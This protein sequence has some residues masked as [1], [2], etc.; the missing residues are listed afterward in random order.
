[1]NTKE[2]NNELLSLEDMLLSV[3][4]KLQELDSPQVKTED[5]KGEKHISREMLN[6]I[7]RQLTGQL[8]IEEME[9]EATTPEEMKKK[10]Q[11]KFNA[12]LKE[13]E[14]DDTEEESDKL[15]EV[16]MGNPEQIQ[17]TRT[18]LFDTTKLQDSPY[19]G[20]SE[21]KLLEY[22]EFK[23]NRM[24][25]ACDFVLR[26]YSTHTLH[27]SAIPPLYD[28]Q[29]QEALSDEIEK[30]NQAEAEPILE[31]SIDNIERLTKENDNTVGEHLVKL[32]KS[33][34]L[35]LWVVGVLGLITGIF[36]IISAASI[37]AD[38]IGFL[39]LGINFIAILVAGFFSK[40]T[41]IS[42]LKS[43]IHLKANRDSLPSLAMV[44][45]LIQLLFMLFAILTYSPDTNLFILTPVA[46]L[47]MAFHH[48]AKYFLASRCVR[49]LQT[50]SSREEMYGSDIVESEE[51]AADITKGT[52]YKKPFV[53]YNR[54]TSFI[55]HFVYNSFLDDMSDRLS[56]FLA[57]ASVLTSLVL[58]FIIIF[59][60]GSIFESATTLSACLCLFAPFGLMLSIQAPLYSLSKE[61]E[62]SSSAILGFSAAEEFAQLNATLTTAH[63]LFP[64][65]SVVLRGMRAFGHHPIDHSILTAASMLYATNSIL[66]D[67]FMQVLLNRTDILSPVDSVLLEDGLGISG[68]V[69]NRHVII[70]NRE[71]AINHNIEVP[72]EDEEKRL[73]PE[74]HKIVYLCIS[75]EL[76]A[77]FVFAL[78]A[79]E[80]TANSL[81]SLSER[82]ISLVVQTVD[83]AISSKTLAEVFGLDE[84]EIKILP[85]RFNATYRNQTKESKNL[86]STVVN[87]GSFTSYARGILN[88]KKL[89]MDFF[90]SS[91]ALL[92]SVIAG[93]L[94]LAV[95]S[96]MG[97]VERLSTFFILLYQL[98]WFGI[99]LAIPY[100][101]SK[102]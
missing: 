97:H 41:I 73:C 6:E 1:M 70:G 89:A 82:E 74:G 63:D 8:L 39:S 13:A 23:K 60:S 30:N 66:R 58:F 49:N 61:N 71:M 11:E 77:A 85:A 91:I 53:A 35:S 20:I 10:S 28:E 52:I 84:Q 87:N 24:Q 96:S 5:K 34:L 9:K 15:S 102:Y 94:I 4:E 64:K 40:D 26:G 46:L 101:R 48:G 56:F 16:L 78:S 86:S 68:W 54:K 36:P 57:P 50:I 93:V 38:K 67:M 19:E 27:T 3:Q 55:T 47:S 62:E 44:G 81:A 95:F 59:V 22:H 92:A 98:I 90:I 42:G 79:D 99:T 31:Q 17:K 25:K 76:T 100:S 43:L 75:G 33:S 37:A 80:K 7:T 2:K 32:K 69:D 83:P 18:Q 88:A 14:S 72:P 12:F 65:G 21:R 51:L 29:A 45:S